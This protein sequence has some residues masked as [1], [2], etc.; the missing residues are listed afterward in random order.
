MRKNEYGT[1][2]QHLEPAHLREVLIPV[3][4][5]RARLESVAASVQRAVEAKEASLAQEVG[6]ASALEGLLPAVAAA[7]AV[8]DTN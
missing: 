8:A 4:V 6:A 3:P 2:Q 5:E 1:I 7:D